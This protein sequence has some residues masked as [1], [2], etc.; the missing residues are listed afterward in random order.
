MSSCANRRKDHFYRVL[1]SERHFAASVTI[2]EE[3]LPDRTL[4][5]VCRRTAEDRLEGQVDANVE[6]LSVRV[7]RDEA[8]PKGGIAQPR[9]GLKLLRAGDARPYVFDGAVLGETDY[10]FVL[11]FTRPTL[12]ALGRR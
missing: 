3:G 1:L 10:S 6:T 12:T 9:R 5:A 4:V 7:G 8:H 2:R 11:Q